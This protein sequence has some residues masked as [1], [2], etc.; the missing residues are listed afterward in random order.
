MIVKRYLGTVKEIEDP[1]FMRRVR[2]T[3]VGLTENITIYPWAF[4]LDDQCIVPEVDSKVW[5][6]VYKHQ[7]SEDFDYSN[8]YYERWTETIPKEAIPD[9]YTDSEAY[10]ARDENSMDGE[11][12][13]TSSIEYPKNRVI[14]VS[15][16]TIELD[17]GN[18]RFCVTDT[19]GNYFQFQQSE[20]IVKAKGDLQLYAKDGKFKIKNGVT[21]MF[22][23]M[24]NLISCMLDLITPGNLTGNMGAPVVFTKVADHLSNITTDSTNVGQFLEE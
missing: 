10:K 4:P 18:K 20:T 11:P 13:A 12:A 15:G 8:V 22:T 3:F 6:Y 16:I 9:D 19:H 14:K 17:E 7:D 23:L 24:D 21:S 1:E 5:L 2:V